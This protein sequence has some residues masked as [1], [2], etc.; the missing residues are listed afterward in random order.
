ML[1]VLRFLCFP[2]L[3]LVG[4]AALA[5][6]KTFKIATLAQEGA[7]WMNEMQAASK[8]I[9][10]ETEQRV[11]FRFY[12]GGV[13][14]SD[15][16]VIRKVRIRQLQ[17]AAVGT[18]ALTRFYGDLELY[19]LPMIFRSYEEVDHVRQHFDERISAGLEAAGFVNFGFAEAGFA[20]AM[21]K[22][23]T[24]SVEDMRR[25]KVWTPVDDDAA[26]RAIKAF[27]ISPIPLGI[28]DVL[29]ALQTGTVN[30]IAGPAYA[31][32]G[33][34][35]HTQIKY[36][37]DLPLMYTYGMLVIEAGQF[38]RLSETD[39]AIVRKHFEE[40]FHTIDRFTRKDQA[41]ALAALGNQ[42][43]E[44][45]TPTDDQKATWRSLAGDALQE[46]VGSGLVT[47]ALYQQIQARLDTYRAR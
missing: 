5:Q 31:A 37:L 14:G 47:K 39:Q 15:T 6:T 35:W 22:A 28:A 36:L 42:G 24:P 13:M 2:L 34:Q 9:Y 46:V 27:G 44:F 43:I 30:A 41:A 33:L 23:P 7:Q 10:A 25:Q 3:L 17:G 8:K 16:Q 45:I 26:L 40:A 11:R 38:A 21:T 1:S 29:L 32:L 12:G 4:S 19:N 18:G 20:Y